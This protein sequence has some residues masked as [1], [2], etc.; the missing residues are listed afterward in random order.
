[1]RRL[2][3][4]IP[5]Y[6]CAFQGLY[7]GPDIF[8]R[9]FREE[10]E[11]GGK[12]EERGWLFGFQGGYE[13]VKKRIPYFG[14]DL[15]YAEGRTDYDG[16]IQKWEDFIPFHSFTDN[17][18][19]NVEGRIGYPFFVSKWRFIPFAGMG[20]QRWFR[21]AVDRESGYDEIFTWAYFAQGVKVY[22]QG[23]RFWNLGLHL[24]LM[25]MKMSQI[26]IRDYY[27][28]SVVLTLGNK[29][30]AEIELPVSYIRKRYF[31]NLTPYYRYLPIGKSQVQQSPHG[32]FFEPSSSTQV[33]GFRL[34]AGLRF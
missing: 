6:L 13:L 2:F 25:E 8:Y 27:P 29:P 28:W 26:E 22:W 32:S 5:V 19:F 24:K 4:F 33:L 23:G 14:A 16:T 17:T 7:L 11:N 1:M 10:I 18:L 20:Y 34:E 12:S 30:Q 9:E 3:V 15:R 21:E 31:L